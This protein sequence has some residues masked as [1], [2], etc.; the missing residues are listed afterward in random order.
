VIEA[1][2]REQGYAGL[3]PDLKKAVSIIESHCIST[4][5]DVLYC[6]PT[7]VMSQFV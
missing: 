6:I 1:A 2:C 3:K 4:L 7:N 5:Y